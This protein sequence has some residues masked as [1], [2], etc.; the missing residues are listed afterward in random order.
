MFYFFVVVVVVVFVFFFFV[1]VFLFDTKIYAA[2]FSSRGREKKNGNFYSTIL[3]LIVF[4]VGCWL[5]VVVIVSYGVKPIEFL[6]MLFGFFFV[7]VLYSIFFLSLSL[8][9]TLCLSALMFSE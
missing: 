8:S 6:N 5:L 3:V 9:L 4:V 1:F 2:K 7:V